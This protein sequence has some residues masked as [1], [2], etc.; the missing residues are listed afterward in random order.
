MSDDFDLG[1]YFARIGYG[2]PARADLA[3]LTALHAAHVAAIPFEG[4]NPLV[5]LP[6]KLDLASLQAKM[7][8]GRRGGYCFEQNLLLKAALEALGYTV[9]S[10]L[11]RVMLGGVLRPT[12]HL[13]LRVRGDG[14]GGDGDGGGAPG[15]ARGPSGAGW[16]AD[17]G[18]GSGTLLQ[19]L[20]WG[21]GEVHEQAGWRFRIVERGFQHVLQCHEDGEWSDRCGFVPAPVPHADIEMSNWFVSTHPASAFVTGILVSRQWPDGRRLI[22]SDWGELGLVERTAESSEST[23]VARQEIPSLLAERF[24][25]PGFALDSG[26]RVTRAT[27]QA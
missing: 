12:T 5:G 19:P 25:L 21:P 17:A 27:V 9:D 20:P 24:E 10:F 22:L 3:T 2:G 15:D 13:V 26:G 7:V 23:P 6:V 16:L 18:F 14:D 8:A 11:A 4:L 1:A